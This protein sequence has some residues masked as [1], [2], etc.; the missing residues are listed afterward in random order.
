[1]NK[2]QTIPEHLSGQ[3]IAEMPG[4]AQKAFELLKKF[5]SSPD[6]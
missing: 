2:A 1:M 3:K 4:D 6:K 5:E